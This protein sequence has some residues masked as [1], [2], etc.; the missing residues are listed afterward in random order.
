MRTQLITA[1]A[2]SLYVDW[3]IAGLMLIGTSIV[4]VAGLRNA[5]KPVW[6]EWK[7]GK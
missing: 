3:L 2:A 5:L 6:R 7:E 1:L 4:V